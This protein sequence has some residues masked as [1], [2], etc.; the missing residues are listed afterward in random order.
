MKK[1]IKNQEERTHCKKREMKNK[2]RNDKENSNV[3][4]TDTGYKNIFSRT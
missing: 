4:L 2:R 3:K 1:R